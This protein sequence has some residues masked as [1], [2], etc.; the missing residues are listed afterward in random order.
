MLTM[1]LTLIV[2][3][4]VYAVCTWYQAFVNMILHTLVQYTDAVG[5]WAG[6]C[7]VTSVWRVC[8]CSTYIIHFF[9]VFS[10]RLLQPSR[11]KVWQQD[12]AVQVNCLIQVFSFPPAIVPA[13]LL[14]SFGVNGLCEA[15]SLCCVLCG[16]AYAHSM[17]YVCISVC[18]AW[19][20]VFESIDQVRLEEVKRA[21]LAG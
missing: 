21:L 6:P 7:I 18:C 10:F 15:L 12:N 17:G 19:R 3:T 14:A 5:M 20:R 9:V 13:S 1:E 4:D 8:M 16:V 2:A 11:Q